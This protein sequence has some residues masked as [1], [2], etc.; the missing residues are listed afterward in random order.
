MAKRRLEEKP[1]EKSPPY[2]LSSTCVH[3][4]W[5]REN[6]EV[7]VLK[8]SVKGN[9]TSVSTVKSLKRR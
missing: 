5:Q 8:S 9:M 7:F 6:Q 3:V 1:A 4:I 2:L